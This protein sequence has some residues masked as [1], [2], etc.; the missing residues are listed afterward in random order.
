MYGTEWPILCWHAVKKLLTH[1]LTIFQH[2][3]NGL[4]PL[5]AELYKRSTP[6]SEDQQP[7]QVY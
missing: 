7:L 3:A 6:S 4:A 5:I 1:S 2:E